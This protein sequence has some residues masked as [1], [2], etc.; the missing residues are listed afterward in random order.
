MTDKER[1]LS[2]IIQYALPHCLYNHDVKEIIENCLTKKDTLQYGD[3]VVAGSTIYPNDYSIGFVNEVRQDCV[4]IRKIGSSS[5]CKYYNESFYR[6][7]KDILGYE[8]LEG[9]HYKIYRKVLKAFEDSSV[10]YYTRFKS[11]TF[12]EDECIVEAREAFK[13]DAIFTISFKYERSTTIKQIAKIISEEERR[14]KN[15]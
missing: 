14:L 9:L 7:N 12:N 13:D 3:L 5:L 1:M 15:V 11:I 6:I 8:I 4:V 2:R 10:R